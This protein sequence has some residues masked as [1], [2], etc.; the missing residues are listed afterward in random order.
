LKT[1]IIRFPKGNNTSLSPK[2]NTFASSILIPWLPK[3][4]YK[5]LAFA[6]RQKKIV[7]LNWLTEQGFFLSKRVPRLCRLYKMTGLYKLFPKWKYWEI[8]CATASRKWNGKVDIL[9]GAYAI[10]DLYQE[11]VDLMKIVSCIQT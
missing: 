9:V 5:V 3:I 2:E 11:L 1:R 10:W 4:L 8:L 6:E 7:V